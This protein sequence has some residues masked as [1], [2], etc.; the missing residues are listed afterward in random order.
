[1][2]DICLSYDDMEEVLRLSSNSV[3]KDQKTVILDTT[4]DENDS[5]FGCRAL[6]RRL[7]NPRG[8]EGLEVDHSQYCGKKIQ[9]DEQGWYFKQPG[10][11]VD[12]PETGSF[13]KAFEKGVTYNCPY[14][15]KPNAGCKH[16][17]GTLVPAGANHVT[18]LPNDHLYCYK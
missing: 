5:N 7:G 1:M 3:Q 16:P 13:R 11:K 12:I 10:K 14:P 9:K 17:D 18:C 4:R 6:N 15:D 2:D 8:K